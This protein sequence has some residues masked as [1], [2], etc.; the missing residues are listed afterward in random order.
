MRHDDE[1]TGWDG[2]DDSV[3]SWVLTNRSC[4]KE[5]VFE[6]T[7]GSSR[8]LPD[9]NESYTLSRKLRKHFWLFCVIKE[10]VVTKSTTILIFWIMWTGPIYEE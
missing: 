9:E 7:T 4:H 3:V 10:S 8:I 2:S 1:E 5:F 6:D